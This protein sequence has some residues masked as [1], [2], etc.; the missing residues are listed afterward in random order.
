MKQTKMERE[1]GN[2]K[3]KWLIPPPPPPPP[4]P[5][6]WT[7]KDGTE[8]VTNQEI[9]KFWRKKRTEE[10]GHLL[11]AIKAAARI[12]ARNLTEEDYRQFEDSLKDDDDDTKDSKL[13]KKSNATLNK[14][15]ENKEV[16]IGIKDWWTKS[17][18]AYLNQPA[19]ETMDPPRRR[20]SNYIPN[21]FSFKPTALYP[22][23]L[24]VF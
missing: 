17:K 2:T 9:A 24:G 19:L 10:E 12:R 4:L 1:N 21:C 5:R 15:E 22:A 3:S 7:R 6:F 20:N 13:D 14:D 16:R 11:A 8:S 18:Y 23:S